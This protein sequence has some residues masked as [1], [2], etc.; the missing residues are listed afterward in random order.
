MSKEIA[1]TFDDAPMS[2]SLHFESRQRTQQLISLLKKLNIPPV[3]IFSNPCKNE[4][5]SVSVNQLSL[6]K[7]SGNKIGNHTCN[8]P[9]F[10]KVGLDAYSAD[11][12][13]ADKALQ[14]LLAGQKFF[15]YP[16]LNEGADEKMRDQFRDWLNRNGYRNAMVSID[17]D[18]QIVS[19]RLNEAKKLGKKINYNKVRDLYIKHIVTSAEFYEK[20]ATENLGYSPKHILLLHENDSSV[21]YLEALVAEFKNK[22]WKIISAEE[23]FKDPL[24]KTAPKNTYAGNGIIAQSV[25]EKTGKKPAI[26]YYKWDELTKDLNKFLKL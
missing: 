11:T 4:D 12:A 13:K 19:E 17:S 2:S 21:L 15:R 10:D 3:M 16:Y 20:M 7:D 24:Y 23:A 8:H 6:Y 25:F 22:G 1:F 5:V 9:R 18:D 26:T 14:P